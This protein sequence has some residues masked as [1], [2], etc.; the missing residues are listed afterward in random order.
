MFTYDMRNHYFYGS[1]TSTEDFR[2][3]LSAFC[4]NYTAA[5]VARE[6]G[7]QR[8][9][10]NS[11]FNKLRV[12]IAESLEAESPFS[13][14]DLEGRRVG[15]YNRIKFIRGADAVGALDQMIIGVFRPEVVTLDQIRGR[16]PKVWTEVLPDKDSW[17][18][19]FLSVGKYRVV[20]IFTYEQALGYREIYD[21]NKIGINDFED[22][23]YE[24]F[25]RRLKHFN[26]ITPRQR[27]LHLKEN[28]WR[29]NHRDR[30]RYSALLKLLAERPL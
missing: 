15:D 2:R 7:R 27:Y 18:I 21:L 22:T 29:F 16:L 30:S 24:F 9:T 12:R 19:K 28:E 1:H 11:I 3:L 26:G 8:N 13:Y 23:F 6:T 4:G 20:Q 14:T 17:T 5:E 25:S 10:I